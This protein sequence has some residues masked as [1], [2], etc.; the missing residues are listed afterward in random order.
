MAHAPHIAMVV[1]NDLRRDARVNKEARTLADAGYR[2]SILS[3]RMGPPQPLPGWHRIAITE[4]DVSNLQSLRTRYVQFWN[5]AVRWLRDQRPDVIHA[6]DLD[7][8]APAW[9]AS[10]ILRVPIV[11]DAHELWTE[12]PSL[13]GRPLVRGVWRTL[14]RLFAPRCDAGITVCDGIARIITRRYGLHPIVL[15][16]MPSRQP[17]PEPIDLR[18]RV[19]ANSET[20]ILLF[21]GGM[22]RGV[23][24]EQCIDLMTLLPHAHLVII[25]GGPLLDEFKGRAAN[26]PAGSRITFIPQ[27]PFTELL[28]YTAGA[29]VGLFLGESAGLNLQLA[30]PNKLFEYISAGIPVVATGWPETGRVVSEYGVGVTVPPG[31]TLEDSAE[32][33]TDA[34]SRTEELAANCAKAR[35]ELVWE[36]DA[37]ALLSLYEGILEGRSA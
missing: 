25:G 35:D 30:L 14:E 2:V 27:V 37:P 21:Q 6:H 1:F 20:P 28:P 22:L 12:L 16:N 9:V 23:G 3:M 18:E 15:R 32:A 11:Y 36:T 31:S 33:I 34:L 10:R 24:I 13:V 26:S 29:D 5:H 7:V 19:G 8:L 17:P 4:V